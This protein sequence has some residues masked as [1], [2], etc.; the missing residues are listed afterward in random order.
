MKINEILAPQEPQQLELPLQ[1]GRSKPTSKQIYAWRGAMCQLAQKVYQ[2]WDQS[3]E[4]YGDPELGFGGICDLIAE[5]IS[6]VLGQY[7]IACTSWNTADSG[8]NHT[9]VIANLADGVFEVDISPYVYETGGGYTWH[10]KPNV[11]FDPDHVSVTRIEAPMTDEDFE[12][13]FH[14]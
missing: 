10:K 2:E 7:D 11:V 1:G 9:S 12:Q 13:R 14:N 5:Q 8:E 4:E 3:D 6:N